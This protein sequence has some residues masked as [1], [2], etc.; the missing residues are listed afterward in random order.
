M[1]Y[2]SRN[3]V[4]EVLIALVLYAL[5]AIYSVVNAQT[6]A[7]TGIQTAYPARPVKIV[8]GFPAGGGT[9]V[10]ARAVAQGLSAALG[11]QFIVDNKPGAG[12]VIAS[13]S[14]LQALAGASCTPSRCLTPHCAAL[15]RPVDRGRKDF[16]N[17][18]SA[19]APVFHPILEEKY[20][21]QSR[22]RQSFDAANRQ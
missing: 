19:R 22:D 14:L 15:A 8:V 16:G 6:G 13:Q 3:W 5:L 1:P 20:K 11:Q 17:G 18:P 9:D 10:F 2:L 7:P 4:S 21:R 12:G